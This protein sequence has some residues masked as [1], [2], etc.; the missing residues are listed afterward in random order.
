MKGTKAP[1]LS[2]PGLAAA[3][4]D[5]CV[6]Q[7]GV[8]AQPIHRG[9]WRAP[10]GHQVLLPQEPL[11]PLE[12]F[13]SP[14]GCCVPVRTVLDR[15]HSWESQAGVAPARNFLLFP[16][17]SLCQLQDPPKAS[18][19]PKFP[20]DTSAPP[21]QAAAKVHPA[22]EGRRDRARCFIS[23]F[24]LHLHRKGIA[25]SLLLLWIRKE[26]L[27]CRYKTVPWSW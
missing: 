14:L 23:L 27:F 20:W 16:K 26:S 2:F 25:H 6:A 8:G 1:S 24:V 22:G 4:T 10:G 17:V 19:A 11:W 3:V 15:N 7:L 21:G 12:Q 18:A 5:N 9:V 13:L